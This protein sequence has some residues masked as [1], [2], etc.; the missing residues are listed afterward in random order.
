M[1]SKSDL[2][3]S[4]S[5]STINRC[6]YC[7]THTPNIGLVYSPERD[8]VS[9][10]SARRHRA[11]YECA[12]CGGFVIAVSELSKDEFPPLDLIIPSPAKVDSALPVAASAYLAQA[13]ETVSSPDASTVMSASAV[14]A[15][16]KHLKYTK[17]T[18]YERIQKT[19][20]DN[21]LTPS[22][23]AWADHIRLGANEVR[24]ADLNSPHRTVQEAQSCVD[25]AT[26]LG[27]FLFTLPKAIEE[28]M[29]T[30]SGPTTPS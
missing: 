13:I 15:M 19:V 27:T 14:D 3:G 1:N 4:R 21:I 29:K 10:I 22:M 30:S 18:L 6:P 25:F 11:V 2:V 12:T 5:L 16:L 28:G 9:K 23:A 8:P 24:H 7:S 20:D 17:G 26:A